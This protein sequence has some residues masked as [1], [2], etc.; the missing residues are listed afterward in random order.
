VSARACSISSSSHECKHTV[1]IGSHK[2]LLR[3]ER[4]SDVLHMLSERP[5]R[6]VLRSNLIR[7]IMRARAV[8]GRHP[9]TI[10]K[11]QFLK[12]VDF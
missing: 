9:D 7:R 2:T 1:V 11:I 12:R 4:F 8:D 6:A 5:L 3:G 10:S